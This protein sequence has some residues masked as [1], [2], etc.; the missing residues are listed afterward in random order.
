MPITQITDEIKVS[1]LAAEQLQAIV[2]QEEG[3]IGIRIYIA[4]SGCS[5]MSYGMTYV[6]E[7]GKNDAVLTQGDLKLFVDG[8]ILQYLKGTE[9][10]FKDDPANPSFVFSNPTASSGGCGSCSSAGSCSS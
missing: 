5:G 7:E 8:E 1:S 9:I 10:D 6:A 2:N 3:V 4:G